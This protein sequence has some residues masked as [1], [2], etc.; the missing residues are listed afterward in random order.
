MA[1]GRTARNEL[2]KNPLAVIASLIGV[3][4]AAFVYPVTKL[5]GP[6]QTVFVAFMVGFPVLLMMC[7][8]LTVWFKPGHLYS[9]GEYETPTDF[10]KG[11]GKVSAIPAQATLDSPGSKPA[12]PRSG[13][14]SEVKLGAEEPVSESRPSENPTPERRTRG[15]DYLRESAEESRDL[16]I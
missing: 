4:E 11:I 1:K 7:F 3:V 15:S 16:Q 10:L 6:N 12:R 5:S 13:F 9:P 8:F 2:A 14:G